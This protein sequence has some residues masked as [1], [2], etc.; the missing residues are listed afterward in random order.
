MLKILRQKG[1]AKKVLW[2]VA[3]I[4]IISFGFGF[5]VS[6]YS[7]KVSLTDS[8]GKAFGK[9]ITIR[10]FRD[11]LMD[12]RD[13]AMMMYG[14]NFRKI[15]ETMNM[16]NEAWT[17]LLLIKEADRRG[18]STVDPEVIAF[19]QSIPLFQRDGEFNRDLYENIIKHSFNREP[20]AFE[21][22]IRGQIKIMK[23]F[24]GETMGLN[25][26]D[27]AVRKEYERRN[28]KV[29]VSYTL[30]DPSSFTTG[31]MPSASEL[32][33]YYDA[34]RQDFLEPGS[35]N[36]QFAS[37]P[38]GKDLSADQLNINR[39]KAAALYRNA[40]RSPDFAAAAKTAG[41]LVKETG[42]VSVEQ[43]ELN[44]KW[45]L[46]TLQTIVGSSVGAILGPITTNDSIQVLKVIDKKPASIPPFT[47]ITDTVKHKVIAEQSLALANKKA[48][49]A[50]KVLAGKATA[51]IPFAAAATG[52]NLPVKTT[53]F[54]S[55]GEY[56]PEIG[57][58]DDFAAAAFALNKENPVSSVVTTTRGP[59][60]LYFG[61][62]QPV[63]PK[64]FDE[65][66]ADFSKSLMEEKRVETMNRVIKTIKE[67]AG[68]ETYTDKIK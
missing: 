45:P 44:M 65:V 35:I 5:G 63:D 11:M 67:K 51:G 14:D 56:I 39:E 7:G 52:L 9:K 53:G 28:Q 47:A 15:S 30:V 22:G 40:A 4:I 31:I 10:E 59:V 61:S 2:V 54:F 68:L 38:A 42:L 33:A 43:P 25:I 27:E 49:E 6:R 46:E 62:L 8:A 21:E 23:M 12:T 19:I 50:Q 37:F 1:V 24:R 34:H 16:E 13:Q 26:P 18:I 66:K 60:I 17:R 36:V 64:K 20:R 3:G 48:A 55:L 57:L 29:Q 32:Q 41:A 58:S